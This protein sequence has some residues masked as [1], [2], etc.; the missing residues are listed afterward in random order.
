MIGLKTETLVSVKPTLIWVVYF[1]VLVQMDFIALKVIIEHRSKKLTLSSGIPSTVEGLHATVK[2]TFGIIED[3]TLHYL[4]EDFGDYFTLHSANQIQHEGTIKVV[5]IPSIVLTCTPT[6]NQTDVSNLNNSSSSATDTKSDYQTSDTSSSQNTV[7]LTLRGSPHKSLWPDDIIIP[8]FS[9][10]TEAV[11]K[12]EEFGKNGTLLN[13]PRIRSEIL[14]KLADYMYGCTAYPT[15]LQIGEVAEALVKK[16]PCLT[17]PESRD[18]W[19]GWMYSL[20]YKMGNYR[21]K[22]RSLGCPDVTC[23]SLKNKHHEDR[24]PAKNIKKARKG[25]VSF[26]PHYPAGDSR[27][28]QELDRQLLIAESQKKDCTAI[29]NLM[30]KTF[31]HRRQDIISQQMSILGLPCFTSCKRVNGIFAAVNTENKDRK[32]ACFTFC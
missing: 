1:S 2:N 17:E 25:E 30:C 21:S 28:Q 27:E 6:E 9:V 13:N 3:F 7:I 15:G 11:P 12:N 19:N 18:G 24:A 10:A 16:H 22:L 14:E 32:P 26:L 20:K 29:Q 5:I 23:N 31:A 4:D 8:L